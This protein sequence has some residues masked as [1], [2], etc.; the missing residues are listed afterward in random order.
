M[1]NLEWMAKMPR[2][3]AIKFLLEFCPL[4]LPNKTCEGCVY[5]N[6]FP[7]YCYHISLGLNAYREW[8]G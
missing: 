8:H 2:E 3:E 7:G 5:E 4:Q 1:T 6:D